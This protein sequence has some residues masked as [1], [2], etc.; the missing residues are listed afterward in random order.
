[1]HQ[2]I[3]IILTTVKYLPYMFFKIIS[4]KCIKCK[5]LTFNP[6]IFENQILC[7]ENCLIKSLTC[8][9]C[10]SCNF[11]I[12]FE[13]IECNNCKIQFEFK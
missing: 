13:F 8:N 2:K 11:K 4:N 6:L 12:V 3:M 1:M 9:T 5:K 7:S 10:N